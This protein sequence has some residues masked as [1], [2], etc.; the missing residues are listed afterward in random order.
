M[1]SVI[2][3][4]LGPWAWVALGLVLLLLEIVLPSSFLLWPGIAAVVVGVITVFHGLDNPIWP[5]QAQVIVFLALSLISAYVGRRIMKN[6]NL[7]EDGH[8]VLNQRGKQLVGTIAA[9][10]TAIQNGSGRI[11]IGDTTWKVS[12]P[13]LASGHQVRV[14]DADGSTLKVESVE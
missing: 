5:W 13:D 4:Y 12:G 10:D 7:D 1:S 14:I 11:R 2:L 8:S 6:Q 3:E 9:L